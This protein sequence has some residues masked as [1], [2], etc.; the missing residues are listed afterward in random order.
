M[1]E[2]SGEILRIIRQGRMELVR[3]PQYIGEP[4][5]VQKIFRIIKHD[6][7]NFMRL[8][9]IEAAENKTANFLSGG[10]TTAEEMTIL[11]NKY[12]NDYLEELEHAAQRERP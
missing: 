1:T 4:Q 9:E 8:S 11:W 5:M 6:P 2:I 7:Q 12:L 3:D 10:A